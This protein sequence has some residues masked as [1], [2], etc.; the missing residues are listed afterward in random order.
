MSTTSATARTPSRRRRT[1]AR[2]SSCCARAD[3]K[4]SIPVMLRTEEGGACLS[5]TDKVHRERVRLAFDENGP[6]F[7]VRNAQGKLI[8]QLSE[9]KDGSGQLCVCDAEGRPRA[10]MRV[11]EH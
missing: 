7:E 4:A 10:G 11:S 5:F 6:L 8:F 1:E 2:Q 3:Q 9:A